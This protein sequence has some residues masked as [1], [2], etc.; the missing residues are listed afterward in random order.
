MSAPPILDGALHDRL[1]MVCPDAVARSDLG[2]VGAVAVGVAV[3]ALAVLDTGPLLPTE[4]I[5]LTR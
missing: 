2:A 3:V 5:A 4:L 1:M